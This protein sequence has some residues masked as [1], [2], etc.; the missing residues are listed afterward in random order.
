MHIFLDRSVLEFFV[1]GRTVTER[2]YPDHR[3]RLL[4]AFAEDGKVTL[5]SLDIWN[6]NTCWKES[7]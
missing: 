7:G 4:D 2:F 6:M 1:A 5:R 3:G